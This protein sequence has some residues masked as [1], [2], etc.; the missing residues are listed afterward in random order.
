MKR[1][2]LILIVFGVFL[3]SARERS[4]LPPCPSDQNQC[5]DNCFGT[6]TFAGGNE[7]AGEF[8]GYYFIGQGSKTYANA[9]I[10]D[11]IW[12]DSEF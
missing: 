1:L 11:G 8:R 9:T 12:K 5:Y 7:Y 6:Y 4:A 10:E 2:L 3:G